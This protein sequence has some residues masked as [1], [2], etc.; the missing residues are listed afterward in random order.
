[1]RDPEQAIREFEARLD[2]SAFG[3]ATKASYRLESDEEDAHVAG[4]SN[5]LEKALRRL[6]AGNE[7]A[8]AALVRRAVAIAPTFTHEA[9]PAVVAAELLI[10]SEL[11]DRHDRANGDPAWL[12][13]VLAAYGRATGVVREDFGGM[14]D[15]LRAGELAGD[16][17]RRIRA[18]VPVDSRRNEP[19][20]AV[21]DAEA[22][23]EA[24]LGM[25]RLLVELSSS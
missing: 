6:G 20:A 13:P 19:L 18:V 14:L 2:A 5:L 21:T 15:A 12:E 4:A 22:R 23:A 25:L 7:D 11:T 3:A 9:S 17:E 16:E 10:Y 1:G 24:V 8:A